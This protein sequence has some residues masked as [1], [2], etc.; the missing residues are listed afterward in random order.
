MSAPMTS[1]NRWALVGIV[2]AATMVSQAFGRFA[3]ALVLPSVQRDLEITYTLAGFLGTLNLSAYLLASFGVAWL[4]TRMA[5]DRIMRMG[6]GICVVGLAGMW[7]SPNLAVVVVA[8]LVT[9]AAG[10]TIWIPAP[11]VSSSLV[12]PER[13]AFAIGTV[14]TGIG[15]GFV[16]AG[17]VA[18]MV[19]DDW[20]AVYRFETLVAIVTAIVLWTFLRV[21]V[22]AETRAPSIRALALV[23]SWKLIFA[24]YGAFGLSMS[25]FVNYF[26]TRLE[27]D[28]GFPPATS[29]LVFATFG[30]ASIFGGPLY[31]AVSDRTGR[32]PA[33]IV[34][35]GT[36]AGASLTLLVGAGPWPWLAALVFGLA[37]AGVPASTAA[38]LR[39]HLSAREFG[40]AFGVITLAFGIGQLLGPQVGGYLGDALGSFATVFYLAAFVALTA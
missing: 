20:R 17:W 18:R 8:M 39:D 23:P 5:P 34:G 37:F 26:V 19:G 33:L 12:P 40:S 32:R 14:G 36:M 10:A 15:I 25:L 3:Y 21:P 24:T 13:R 11:A 2:V 6:I 28:S 9:G 27:E 29:A 4:S 1:R 22:E 30:I 7:W 38:Y 35:Y 16:S 31:G